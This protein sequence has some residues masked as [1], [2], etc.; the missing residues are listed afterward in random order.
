MKNFMTAEEARE[1]A[2]ENFNLT[3]EP[4]I[5]K[6]MEV[7]SAEVKEGKRTASYTFSEDVKL[8]T[9]IEVESYLRKNLGYTIKGSTGTAGLY[10][11]NISW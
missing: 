10:T 7:I 8:I 9:A 6:I 1:Q 5:E 2:I 11:I 3:L 4:H